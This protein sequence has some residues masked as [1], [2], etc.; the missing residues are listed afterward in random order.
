MNE[1]II[2]Q[3]KELVNNFYQPLGHLKCGVNNTI[4]WEH[5][6][7]C[8]LITCDEIIKSGKDVDEFSDSYWQEVKQAIEQL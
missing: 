1:E 4:M 7:Q 5:A 3:A 2:K 8:A 6:Q